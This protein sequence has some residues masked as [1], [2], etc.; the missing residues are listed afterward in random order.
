MTP[1]PTTTPPRLPVIRR[2]HR[3]LAAGVFVACLIIALAAWALV[4]RQ[5][6]QADQTRF[7]RLGELVRDRLFSRFQSHKQVLEGFTGL[8]ASS[9]PL[10]R[11]QW[12]EYLTTVSAVNH[13]GTLGYGFIR[14]VPHDQLATFQSQ[15]RPELPT[16]FQFPQPA[17][18]SN[19]FIVEIIEPALRNAPALALDLAA[20][21]A[22]RDVLSRS[23]ELNAPTLS[24]PL[25]LP[26][27]NRKSPGFLFVHPVY[28]R[29]LPLNTPQERWTALLGWSFAPLRIDELMSGITEVTGHQLDFEIFDG[30][31]PERD[32]LLYDADGHLFARADRRVDPVAFSNRRHHRNLA[33]HPGSRPW[34]LS[35]SSTPT[36]NDSGDSHLAGLVLGSGCVVSLLAAML[37]WSLGSSRTRAINLAGEMTSDLRHEVI[38][39]QDAER[40]LR[41]L[42]RLQAAIFDSAAHGILVTDAHGILQQ[43]N[44]AAENLLG[45]RLHDLPGATSLDFFLEPTEL[46]TRAHDFS[47]ILGTPIQPGFDTL[48]AKAAAGLPNEHEW[49]LLRRDRERRRI[50]L[51]ITTLTDDR[52]AVT[53]FLALAADVTARRAAEKRLQTFVEHAPAAVAML[54]RDLRYIAT[55]RRWL[56]EYRIAN[57]DLTGRLHYDVFP[58]VPESWRAI[59]QRCLNGA[60]ETA[61]SDCWRPPGWEHDQYL[62]WEIR[63]WYDASGSVGGLMMFTQDIT[64][65]H[66]REQE[67]VRLRNAAEAASRAKSE[68]LATM[69]HE[70]RTPMN[71]VIGFTNLL[72][73]TPLNDE[74]RDFVQTIHASGQNLLNLI[75]DILDYSKIEAGRI[76]LE[77]IPYDLAET[78]AECVELLH[79]QAEAKGL[80]LALCVHPLAP[81]HLTGDPSRVRQVLLNLVG[82]ALKFTSRGHVTVRITGLLRPGDTSASAAHVDVIDSGIGIPADKLGLLF[83]KFSQTDSS[84]SRRFGGTGL[85]LAISRQLVELMGGSI[86]VQS[87]PGRGSSFHFTLPVL[88]TGP[89][90]ADIPGEQSPFAHEGR[91][92]LVGSSPAESEAISFALETWNIGHA[93][94]AGIASAFEALRTAREQ[95]TPFQ[96]VLLDH[97]QLVGFEQLVP[98][99]LAEAPRTVLL[100]PGALRSESTRYL[101]EGFSA[102]LPRPFTRLAQLRSVLTTPAT[103]AVPQAPIPK[104][105][106]PTTFSP[107]RS[108]P[109][110]RH[111]LLV[112]DTLV[113][114]KL[115][116]QI[117]ERIGCS[118]DLAED[119][120]QAIERA[121]DTRY[122]V[123]LMDCQLPQMDGFEATRRIRALEVQRGQAP[124]TL[125][126]LALTASALPEDRLRCLEAG[127]NDVI[128]KPVRKADLDRALDRWHPL[129]TEAVTQ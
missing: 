72:A 39:R 44:P 77:S 38:E 74:Q 86:E 85:G 80:D 31:Q 14:R 16:G 68:F 110:R 120:F 121:S 101:A 7:D 129:L 81:R 75:N 59:H 11:S 109:A 90:P 87:Q 79:N 18:T 125:P 8:V 29:S 105:A 66:L 54:D 104:P 100:L 115:A 26:Q 52:G 108:Q 5:V 58:S 113:N 4:R 9:D 19:H 15:L 91:V 47:R 65:E 82:N 127:M 106:P 22:A 62:R 34:I 107:L 45:T 69:S 32:R 23:I 37:T 50:L 117:L 96:S 42:T 49:T 10:R 61:D 17:P 112:E 116:I 25:R 21:P 1:V 64:I 6:H 128:V 20:D 103:P 63:P 114:Q 67:L 92:L 60:I 48:S 76:S 27:D 94:V 102:V 124:G 53:G 51:A 40:S 55:S 83:H 95:E 12:R 93:R 119:G 3:V 123:I 126:I 111:V 46:Q 57:Q 89:S 2:S 56:S 84:T 99:L 78:A 118:V 97:A 28:R 70:I 73:D 43:L 13:P 36:F 24:A 41:R 122:D 33:I 71:G 88:S 30:H 98:T 35:L